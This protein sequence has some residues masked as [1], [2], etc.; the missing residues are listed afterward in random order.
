MNQV[1]RP[2]P[3]SRETEW[4]KWVAFKL[5]GEAEARTFD[6]SRCDVL[7]DE[8]A[9]EVEWVKKWKESVGQALFYAAAF[10]R[11]PKIILLTRGKP[12]EELYYLRA[13]VVCN[14]GGIELETL[15]TR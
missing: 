2:S 4:S 3:T 13:S 14:A 10:G 15:D 1:I 5:G 11:K 7:T 9:I 6:G 8:F 12:N